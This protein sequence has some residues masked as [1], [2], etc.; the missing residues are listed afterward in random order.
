MLSWYN[1]KLKRNVYQLEGRRIT[2]Q[3]LGVKGLILSWLLHEENKNCCLIDIK[4]SK[5]KIT[6]RPLYNV[7]TWKGFVTL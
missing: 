2:N 7:F 3:I 4:G 1:T 5:D 6:L